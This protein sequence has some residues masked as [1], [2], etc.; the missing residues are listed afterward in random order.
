MAD[1]DEKE[2]FRSKAIAL[3][4][5]YR[6]QRGDRPIDFLPINTPEISAFIRSIQLHE[7]T[8]KELADFKQ[9]VSDAVV[10]EYLHAEYVP[11]RMQAFIIPKPKP[12]P[13]FEV[14][15]HLGMAKDRAGIEFM[16]NGINGALDA[17][18]FEIR[19]KKNAE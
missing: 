4:N 9:E 3:I 10:T 17:L 2:V 11:E 14:L 7:K 16:A 12:D 18:G 15:W 1:I 5:E 19:E 8:K 13:L 6:F